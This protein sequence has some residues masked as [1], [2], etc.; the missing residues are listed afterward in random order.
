MQFIETALYE[1]KKYCSKRGN[2]FVSM[3]IAREITN[4]IPII[5]NSAACYDVSI[6]V[7]AFDNFM[8]RNLRFPPESSM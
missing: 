1:R 2:W 6:N 5:D 4:K 3:P 8:S 7:F